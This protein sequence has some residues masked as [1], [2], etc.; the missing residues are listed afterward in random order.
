M[1]DDFEE[2]NGDF[3]LIRTWGQNENKTIWQRIL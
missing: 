3:E 2:I 1:K